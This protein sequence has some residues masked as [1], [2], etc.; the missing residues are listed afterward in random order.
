MSSYKERYHM[1][2]ADLNNGFK[3]QDVK[4]HNL[5]MDKLERLFKAV[6][7]EPDKSFLIDLLSSKGNDWLILMVAAHCLRMNIY[8]N[9]ATKSLKE[10]SDR[11]V[12]VEIR[13]DAKQTLRI[14]KQQG[15]L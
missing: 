13:L 5:A 12:I 14:W 15:Y 1:C 9:E 2:C 11:S 8:I 4:R 6:Q 7:N 3:K 10:L